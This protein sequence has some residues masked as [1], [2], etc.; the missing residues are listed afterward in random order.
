MIANWNRAR[1]ADLDVFGHFHYL[2]WGGNFVANGSLIGYGPFSE[3]IAAPFQRPQQ[4]F[5]LIDS[6][7]GLTMQAPI[8]L[9]RA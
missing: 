9:E 8:L 6:Q 3:R 5:F 4:A 1:K 7:F 2:F